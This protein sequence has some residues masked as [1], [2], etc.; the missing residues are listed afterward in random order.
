MW[1][2]MTTLLGL[3]VL[4]LSAIADEVWSTPIG[5]VVYENETDD[6]WAVWSYPGLTDRGTVYIKDL[7]GVYEGRGAYA[8]IWVEAESPNI[9]LCD[10][11]VTDPVTGE[12]HYNWGRVDIVFTEPDFPGGWVALRGNC[13]NDPGD[14]LIGKPVTALQ[15]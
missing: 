8:G 4:S 13:F 15:E 12:S 3:S 10:V 11:A 14:Y 6:G 5:D 7:A 2:S 1:K 9:E